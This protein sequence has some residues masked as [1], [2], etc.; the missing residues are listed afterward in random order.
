MFY[1]LFNS[2]TK[3]HIA[4]NKYYNN[5]GSSIQYPETSNEQLNFAKASSSKASS[6]Q[7]K[8]SKLNQF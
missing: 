1:V 7:P 6:Q 4:H 3:Q 2:N 8:A 5:P